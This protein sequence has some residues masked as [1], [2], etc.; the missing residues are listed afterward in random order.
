M[1]TPP[2]SSIS[3]HLRR[4]DQYLPNVAS[5]GKVESEFETFWTAERE[6]SLA[7]LCATEGLKPDAVSELISQYHFTQRE[8]LREKIVSALNE[9][10]KI[11]ER[12][13]IIERVTKRL[14]EL[15]HTFDDEF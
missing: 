10:P 13:S 15:I 7:E 5:S 14:M 11:L 1:T 6:K 3:S 8:P 9:K 12:R 2:M 4:C